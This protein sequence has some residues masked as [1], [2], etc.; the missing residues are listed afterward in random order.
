M[1]NGNGIPPFLICTD[2]CS[3]LP[4]I[5]NVIQSDQF[6]S[7]SKCNWQKLKIELKMHHQMAERIR[8]ATR[9]IVR[10]IGHCES[11]KGNIIPFP[12]E[13]AS[14]CIERAWI[15]SKCVFY[16]ISSINTTVERTNKS[17]RNVIKSAR[18]VTTAKMVWWQQQ[19]NH[20]L[21]VIQC[22]LVQ[23]YMV[24]M[25]SLLVSRLATFPLLPLWN[26]CLCC[27]KCEIPY[28]V[29][30]SKQFDL[31]MLRCQYNNIDI[32]KK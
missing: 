7:K 8:A 24:W 18:K 11:H 16:A 6:Q 10:V 29:T 20:I 4:P 19:I 32:I 2:W 30:E 3:S 28:S 1:T 5:S 27:S 13:S 23:M 25:L 15:M 31:V 9:R 26:C 12:T 22:T 21:K 14:E 17:E